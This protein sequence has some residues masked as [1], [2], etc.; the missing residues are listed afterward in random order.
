MKV[1]TP[2]SFRYRNTVPDIINVAT[3]SQSLIKNHAEQIN[4]IVECTDEEIDLLNEHEE[5]T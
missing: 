5:V 2:H 3:L 4:A 1:S